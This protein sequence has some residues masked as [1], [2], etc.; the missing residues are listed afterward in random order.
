MGLDHHTHTAICRLKDN[1]R[2]RHLRLR[3]KMQ[4]RLFD[5]NY[6]IRRSCKEGHEHG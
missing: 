4:L 6:L 3:M 2:Q 5:K 1:I